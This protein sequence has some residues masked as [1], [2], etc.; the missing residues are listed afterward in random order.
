ML[1]CYLQLPL[2]FKCIFFTFR[3][4]DLKVTGNNRHFLQLTK[5]KLAHVENMLCLNRQVRTEPGV[6]SDV[7]PSIMPQTRGPLWVRQEV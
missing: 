5:F 2:L 1:T 4:K 7:Y 3:K 6:T